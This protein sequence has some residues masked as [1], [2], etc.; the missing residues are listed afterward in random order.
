MKIDYEELTDPELKLNKTL[1]QEKTCEIDQKSFRHQLFSKDTGV[2][3]TL[4]LIE[5][6]SSKWKSY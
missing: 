2:N 3:I 5:T 4:F 1:G 6:I